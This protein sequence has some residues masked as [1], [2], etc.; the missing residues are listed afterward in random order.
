MSDTTE[1]ECPVCEAHYKVVRVEALATHD[2][3][4]LVLAAALP[5]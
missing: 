1:F 3:L 4:S 5:S 2:V